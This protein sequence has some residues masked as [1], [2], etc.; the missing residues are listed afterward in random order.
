LFDGGG[1]VA[2]SDAPGATQA[3]N[4][5]VEL[6]VAGL[7]RKQALDQLFAGLDIEMVWLNR[8]VAEEALSGNLRGTRSEVARELLAKTN[9]VAAFATVGGEL[10]IAR[11]V[12]VGRASGESSPGLPALETALRQK[13]ESPAVSRPTSGSEP[14]ARLA[15]T[16]F[17]PQLGSVAGRSNQAIPTPRKQ[18]GP[19][20]VPTPVQVPSSLV[21][22][23]RNVALPSVAPVMGVPGTILP[24]PTSPAAN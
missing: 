22:S 8:A 2:A 21:P 12:I 1:Y 20:P 10:R 23:P 5:R 4:A 19:L 9:F 7:T 18:T 3:E 16:S 17:G 6:Q 15:A 24:G 13:K 11:L 14:P